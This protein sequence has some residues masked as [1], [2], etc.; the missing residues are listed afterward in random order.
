MKQTTLFIAPLGARNK[1]E[2][3][4]EEIVSLYPE[5]NFSSVLYLAPN[6]SVLTE[7]KRQFFSYLKKVGRKS[8]HIPFQAFT[9]K[10]LAARI[11]EITP[12]S[13]P[14]SLRGGQGELPSS[15]RERSVISEHMRTLIL[16]GILKDKN[17]GYASILSDLFRKIRHYICDKDLSLLADEIRQLIFEEKTRDRA[18]RAIEILQKYESFLEEKKLIDTEDA[19]KDCISI[20]KRSKDNPLLPLTSYPLP[21]KYTLVIDGFYDPTPLEIEI[22]NALAGNADEAIILAEEN[23]ELLRHFLSHKEALTVKTLERSIHRE[24]T[25]YYS[26]NSV[27]EE[28]EGIAKNIRKLILDG[29]KPWEVTVC[30]PSLLQYLPM[31]R[32]I[33]EKYGIPASIGEYRLSASKPFSALEEIISCVENGYP[34]NDFLS[35]VTSP[36]FP[37]IQDTVK[38]LAVTLSYRAGIIKRKESWL[39]IKDTLVGSNELS[40]Q[41][42]ERIAQFQKGIIPVIDTLENIRKV[43]GISAFADAFESALDRFGFFDYLKDEQ[44][45][46]GERAAESI[47]G[48]FSELRRFSGLFGTSLQAGDAGF[49]LRY[50]LSGLTASDE[51][52]DGVK[53]LPFELAAAAESKALFFGGLT[54]GSF[55]SR[56]GIDPVLPEKVK[57]TLGIP[58]LEYYLERQRLYFT[59]LLNASTFDPYLSCPAADGDKIFLPSPFLDWENLICP[60]DLDIF[61]EEDILVSEGSELNLKSGG[62]AETYFDAKAAGIL[63]GRIGAISK[64]YFRVTDIDYYRR[65]PFKFYLEKILGL[66]IEEPPRFEVEYRQ[67]GNLAHRTMEYL[68]KD[69]NWELDAFEKR[70]FIALEKSLKDIPIGAFWADVTREIFRNL[71]PLLKKQETEIRMQGFRPWLVEEKIEAEISG[72]KLRGKIDRVDRKK[73]Q[74]SEVRSQKT[75]PLEKGD[76]G[77]F[78]DDSV[79]LLDY[80]TGSIDKKSLQLPLYSRMWKEKHPEPLDEAGYYSLKEGK[81]NWYPTKKKSME[82]Y[83]QE[84]LQETAALIEQMK[85]GMFPAE[86]LNNECRNCD[87][88]ALCER[89]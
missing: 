9:I 16:C 76:I 64:K 54:E 37:A 50:L 1:K 40:E 49:Y 79:I 51:T 61:T 8:V 32:R 17:I 24:S 77:G 59:R 47:K 45:F 63:R 75:P 12:P 89:D 62:G 67:W 34:R 20:I 38:K 35:I 41:D 52:I 26:Y 78:P 21:L 55:P 60:A 22:I 44:S 25:G 42:K 83:I 53:V 65:C 29:V 80:K 14:L 10:Q 46:H 28:V 66:E 2:A 5:N 81:V 13:P 70:L 87:H 6:S 74:K 56:P 33:F 57:K 48:Q 58:H 73:S 69:K 85:K 7:A 19:L 43:S 4:F 30:F 82:E 23:T 15:E 88:S 3:I 72:I 86:P 18:V 68:F 11:Y 39:S 31:L 36:C 71:L 84:A 27:E